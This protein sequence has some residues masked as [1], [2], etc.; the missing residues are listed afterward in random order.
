MKAEIFK[1][2]GAIIVYSLVT[3]GLLA[4]AGYNWL[5][6]FGGSDA[7]K[8]AN[9]DN[10]GTGGGA[11]GATGGTGGSRGTSGEL[12]GRYGSES[13]NISERTIGGDE[14]RSFG[15]AVPVST[16]WNYSNIKGNAPQFF[17]YGQNIP[18]NFKVG[19]KVSIGQNMLQITDIESQGIQVYSPSKLI[20]QLPPKG[21][22]K[23]SFGGIV[24]PISTP[25]AWLVTFDIIGQP[26]PANP[27]WGSYVAEKGRTL[28]VIAP[29]AQKASWKAKA[30]AIGTNAGGF[31]NQPNG[32]AN[33]V[34][35]YQE[36]A[37]SKVSCK[38]DKWYSVNF[39]INDANF[40]YN[41]GNYTVQVFGTDK[42]RGS[43]NA[44]ALA[45]FSNTGGYLLDVT[46]Q[47]NCPNPTN[48]YVEKSIKEFTC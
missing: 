28:K 6:W 20:S 11:T 12:G 13:D 44:K 46:T 5:G 42:S 17:L 35:R 39:D 33:P 41:R 18:N 21:T 14:R 2:T 34:Y 8:E 15:Q 24:N 29:D 9:P 25:K 48:K 22:V 31:L 7:W 36:T 38:G 27:T 3:L 23:K 10:S 40:G 4:I 30:L 43:I 45:I 1:S 16:E 37:V 26:N 32:C 47:P 19:D